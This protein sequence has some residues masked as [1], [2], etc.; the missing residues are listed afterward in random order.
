MCSSESA[1]LRPA[2]CRSQQDTAWLTK[3]I[4]SSFGT[5]S[6]TTKMNLTRVLLTYLQQAKQSLT[7]DVQRWQR[8]VYSSQGLVYRNNEDL[9]DWVF[10]L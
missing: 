10:M 8:L 3:R 1:A 4:S 7:P 2:Q 9:N 6:S 5:T